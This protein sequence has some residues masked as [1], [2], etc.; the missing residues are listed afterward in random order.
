LAKIAKNEAC[1]IIDFWNFSHSIYKFLKQDLKPIKGQTNEN[2]H[3]SSKINWIAVPNII[4]QEYSKSSGKG[5]VLEPANVHI[6]LA[7][8]QKHSNGF[9]E[10]L[11]YAMDMAGFSIHNH[12]TVLR[13]T[14]CDECGLVKQEYKEKG[15]DVSIAVQMLTSKYH[16]IFLLSEDADL[17]PAVTEVQKHNKKVINVYTSGRNTFE[18]ISFNAMDARKIMGRLIST[19]PGKNL[20]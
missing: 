20:G 2:A 15:V 16:Y 17:I 11:L 19:I 6:H 3:K 4:V 18:D 14:K 5:L 10:K 7:Y 13:E 1:V 8:F 12:P 9:M